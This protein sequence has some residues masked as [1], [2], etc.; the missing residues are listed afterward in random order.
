MRRGEIERQMTARIRLGA[1]L[2]AGTLLVMDLV[3]CKTPT[4][5]F[6][7]R[8]RDPRERTD[9]KAQEIAYK[10]EFDYVHAR[11]AQ[12]VGARLDI[13]VSTDPVPPANVIGLALSGGGIRSATFSLGFL[14]GLQK[15]ETL[16]Q[17]D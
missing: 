13:R 1:L 2:F 4:R 10:E 12:L 6:E 16:D 9:P 15:T 17:I 3:A 5:E 8:R 11:R 14:Q 7:I